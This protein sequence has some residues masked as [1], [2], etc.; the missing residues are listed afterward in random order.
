MAATW[1]ILG[2]DGI[3]TYQFFREKALKALVNEQQRSPESNTIKSRPMLA[4][5]DY[6][7]NGYRMLPEIKEWHA[8]LHAVS[9]KTDHISKA[10]LD[11]VETSM[12]VEDGRDR[13]TAGKL[14]QMLEK[15]LEEIPVPDDTVFM[16]DRLRNAL[17]E[18][19]NTPIVNLRPPDEQSARQ[20]E[21]ENTTKLPIEHKPY[22]KDRVRFFR[23]D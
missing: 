11:I 10:V 7:H 1:V 17:V 15:I 9:R 23:G 5:G 13:I 18:I 16:S 6:F 19:E 12:L 21:S 22:K 14:S 2:L 8:Y 4:E 3:R 20:I